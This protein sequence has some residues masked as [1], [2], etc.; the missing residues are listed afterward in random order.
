MKAR[1]ALLGAFAA[2]VAAENAGAWAVPAERGLLEANVALKCSYRQSG[3]AS[4]H[5]MGLTDGVKDSDIAPGCY[6]TDATPRLPK[7]VLLDLGRNY[8]VTQI[9]V[10]NSLNG[11]TKTVA[12]YVGTSP[13]KLTYLWK[14][15]FPDRELRTF[16]HE[17]PEMPVRYVKV[18]F[19]DT[20]GG[21]FGGD[22]V[23]YL[24]EV[25]VIARVRED[26]VKE[27]VAAS[28]TVINY[29]RVLRVLRRVTLA[30]T[31]PLTLLVAVSRPLAP[32]QWVGPVR[33]AL[34]NA[35]KYN[36]EKT[37]PPRVAAGVLPPLNILPLSSALGEEAV[38]EEADLVIVGIRPEDTLR[39]TGV[40][41]VR[42][43][44][45]LCDELTGTTDAVPLLVLLPTP[46]PDPA[47]PAG[48]ALPQLRGALRQV[49]YLAGVGVFDCEAALGADPAARPSMFDG[50]GLLN[51][52]GRAFVARTI[53]EELKRYRAR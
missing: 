10:Y 46:S 17:F 48:R 11:N 1:G 7:W 4:D 43:L 38:R 34:V 47:S 25:E 19:E 22:Y 52:F 39:L 36:A 33:S 23:M 26:E 29:P 51:E 9:N 37:I 27:S 44:T 20:Y 12:L 18:V 30:R 35:F 53:A 40:D 45:A 16:Q 3:V 49:G 32:A 24:R 2:V 5:W 31:F 14:H 28:A 50:Q 15:L 21:G 6:A 42:T 41:V 13:D 8:R